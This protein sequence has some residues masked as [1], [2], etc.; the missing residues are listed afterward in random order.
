MT[1]ELDSKIN[2]INYSNFLNT[3]KAKEIYTF[4]KTSWAK[5]WYHKM[6]FSEPKWVK[7]SCFQYGIN[8]LRLKGLSILYTWWCHYKN[9]CVISYRKCVMSDLYESNSCVI[10]DIL[11][12]FMLSR[13]FRVC[14]YTTL[15][16]SSAIYEFRWNTKV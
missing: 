9:G 13:Q 2:G 16:Y 6:G 5:R 3:L 14:S 11:F 7:S 12:G 4:I 15:P 10:C 8:S 1:Y